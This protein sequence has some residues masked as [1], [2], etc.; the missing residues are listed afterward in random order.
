MVT[1]IESPQTESQEPSQSSLVSINPEFGYTVKLTNGHTGEEVKKALELEQSIWDEND[2]GS[3]DEYLKYLDQSRIFTAW[4]GEKCIG[5]TRV[6]EGRPYLPPFMDLPIT[7]P[8]IRQTLESDCEAGLIEELGTAAVPKSERPKRIALELWR[9]AYRDARARGIKGWG[10]IM[11]PKRVAVMNGRYDFTFEQLGPTVNYQ[12]GDCAVH[13]LDLEKVDD[14][15]KQD[16]PGLYAWFV[17]D[18]L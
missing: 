9:L 7:D 1:S 8:N 17:E 11:E 6:F 10:I 2:Y 15:M 16:N 3:L 4:E 18:P 12:G 14:H 5:V 13:Y